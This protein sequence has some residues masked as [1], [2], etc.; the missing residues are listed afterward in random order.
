MARSPFREFSVL[1]STRPGVGPADAAKGGGPMWL[2]T[3]PVHLAAELRL[4]LITIINQ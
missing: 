4:P 1:G 2:A 3:V